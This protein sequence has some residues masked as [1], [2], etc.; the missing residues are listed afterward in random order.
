MGERASGGVISERVGGLSLRGGRVSGDE[1]ARR[2]RDDGG[3][4]IR[5]TSGKKLSRK[6]IVI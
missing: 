1:G 2:I 3:K 5:V 4:R 6:I